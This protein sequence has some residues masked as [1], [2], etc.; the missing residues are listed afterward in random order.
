LVEVTFDSIGELT[1]EQI[2]FYYG[3]LKEITAGDDYSF[4]YEFKDKNLEV[5]L[6]TN[7]K[8]FESR[9]KALLYLTALRYVQEYPEIVKALIAHKDEPIEI[10]FDKFQEIHELASNGKIRLVKYGNLAGHGLMYKM[11]SKERID[12]NKFKNNLKSSLKDS[13]NSYFT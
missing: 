3:F 11:Y 8:N 12:L 2:N 13:V 10:K 5:S 4:S 9:Y 1:K 7:P 6:K